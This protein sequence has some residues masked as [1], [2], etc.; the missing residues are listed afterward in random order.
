MPRSAP[1]S[2][3]LNYFN[4]RR[5]AQQRFGLLNVVAEV[6]GNSAN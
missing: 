6:M 5:N 2:L 4:R 1:N 3:C